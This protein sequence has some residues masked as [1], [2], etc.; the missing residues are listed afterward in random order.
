MAK[1]SKIAWTDHTFN[2]WLGCQH[3]SKG[4]DH[5]YADTLMN[6]MGLDVFGGRSK[7]QR[8]KGPWVEVPR[9]NRSA[10]RVEKPAK[11]FCASLADVFEDAPGPNEWRP[12]AW[13]LIRACPWLDF[14]LLTKRPENIA[15]MLPED[16]GEGWPNVWLGTSIEDREV[17]FRAR[18]LAQVPAFVRF[19]SYEP[20][21]GPVFPDGSIRGGDDG[22]AGPSWRVWSD[23]YNGPELDLD[24]IGWLIC[25]G[26]SGPGFRPMGLRWAQDAHEACRNTGTP[27]FF[28]QIAAYRNEQRADALGQVI[29]EF[30]ASWDRAGLTLFASGGADR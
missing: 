10:E 12:E 28:K 2:P 25:G 13:D 22:E 16:W 14:Q 6:R 3:W 15:A 4:C 19:I 24:G 26:E 5:C 20:A 1:N 21:I 17:V 27:F 23:G 9:W 18:I 30:P 7:R 29:R 11:V 8:T